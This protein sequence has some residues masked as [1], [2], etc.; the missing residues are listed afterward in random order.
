MIQDDLIITTSDIC[1]RKEKR[2]KREQSKS[3][4]RKSQLPL[5][6]ALRSGDDKPTP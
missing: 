5:P 4:P 3:P 1:R 2:L 6:S